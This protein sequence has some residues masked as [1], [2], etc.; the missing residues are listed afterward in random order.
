MKK[1][2]LKISMVELEIP[3][4]KKSTALLPILEKNQQT[5]SFRLKV[6][7]Y[8]LGKLTHRTKIPPLC[9]TYP[10]EEHQHFWFER[11]RIYM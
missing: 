8:F 3:Y 11:S 5:Y 1:N 9:P 10:L 2:I 7:S 6:I 4:P